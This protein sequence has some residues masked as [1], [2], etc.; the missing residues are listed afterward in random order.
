MTAKIGTIDPILCETKRVPPIAFEGTAGE[1]HVGH[2]TRSGADVV[3]MGSYRHAR[4]RHFVL[5]GVTSSI[6][7]RATTPLLMS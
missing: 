1:L 2:A 5:G 4:L 6:I 7:Q 3:V